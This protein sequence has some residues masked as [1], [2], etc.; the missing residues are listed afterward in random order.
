MGFDVTRLHGGK[1]AVNNMY[2]CM[3]IGPK[4]LNNM[5]RKYSLVPEGFCLLTFCRNCRHVLDLLR[6]S[7]LQRLQT[8]TLPDTTS[9]IDKIHPFRI[10]GMIFKPL[11]PPFKQT[12]CSGGCSTSTY[13]THSFTD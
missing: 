8:Q 10:I 13:V 3:V 5:T 1:K 12:R 11:M 7:L 2:F 4:P 9:P 6:T